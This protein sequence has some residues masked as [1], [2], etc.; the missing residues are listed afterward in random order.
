[1]PS[2]VLASVELQSY[3]PIDGTPVIPSLHFTK[4]MFLE[5]PDGGK[6]K[7]MLDGKKIDIEFTDDSD[8]NPS[9][10]KLADE[11]NAQLKVER[12]S[13]VI[14]TKLILNYK[15]T[16]SGNDT[17]TSIEYN[18]ILRPT[19]TGYIINQRN[20][21]ENTIY[22][23]AWVGFDIKK[24]VFITTEEYENLEINFP[25][26]AIQ[27]NLPNVYSML[28][29]SKAEAVLNQNLIDTS[30]LLE[31]PID[32][33]NSLFDP[34]YVVTDSD[35]L[36]QRGKKITGTI[37]STGESAPFTGLHAEEKTTTNFIGDITYGLSTTEK[38]S[39]GSISVDGIAHG[40]VIQE[41]PIISTVG[42]ISSDTIIT[43]PERLSSMNTIVATTI[44]VIAIA[45]MIFIVLRR[46]KD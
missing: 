20:N 30:P 10:K 41:E 33:W 7:N 46:K 35:A 34:T 43:F 42:K 16:L 2:T 44:L 29:G 5:Y 1:M 21:S 39:S 25:L 19:I 8:N 11:I 22:D 38:V 6:L 4:T 24:P 27:R 23:A 13:P 37:F 31:Q 26:S 45:M 32:K 12:K 15:M 28:N 14:I 9:I 18:V 36:G 3:L 40:Y 17:K